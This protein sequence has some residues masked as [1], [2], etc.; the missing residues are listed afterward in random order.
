MSLTP[1]A[2]FD[3]IS[4]PDAASADLRDTLQ[5]W[6][7]ASS[8]LEP[9]ER[10][11]ILA[12]ELRTVAVEAL[13]LITGLL[14]LRRALIVLMQSSAIEALALPFPETVLAA[15]VSLRVKHD[16]VALPNVL[17]LL[18]PGEGIIPIV[19]TPTPGAGY[20]NDDEAHRLREALEA[21][22]RALL[23]SQGR[24]TVLALIEASLRT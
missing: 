5:K 12:R 10:G 22:K 15:H 6:A 1:S 9:T 16:P 24:D 4:E 3:L 19:D 23:Q 11:L 13:D 8:L 2:P 17:Q 21:A 18:L 14:L 7:L 20:G